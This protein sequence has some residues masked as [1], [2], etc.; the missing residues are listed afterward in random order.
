M[1]AL[2]LSYSNP[3]LAQNN[4]AAADDATEVILI[5]ASLQREA[6]LTSPAS[7]ELA[8]TP[9]QGILIDSAQL[10]GSIS[11]VQADSR[12]NFAQDTRLSVR[13]FGSRSAFGIRSLYLQQDGIPISTPDGQGQLSSILL[14]NIDSVEVLKGPLA[15]LYGNAS[16]GVLSLY[17]RTPTQ[18]SAGLAVAGS[19]QHRQYQVF[20]DWVA[21]DSSLS[22][23][24]KH[25][26]TDGFRPHSRAEKQ[27]AQL[28]YRTTLADTARLSARLDYARDPQLQD[29]LGLSLSD[30]REQPQQTNAAAQLFDTEKNSRQRQFSLSF[31]D[32]QQDDQW[33]LSAWLGERQIN[34]RLAFTGSAPTS[35]GGEVLLDR[36]FSGVNGHY[37]LLHSD[38]YQLRIGASLMQSEDDRLGFVNDFGQ[39][40]ALRRQQTDS[41][42]NRD[43]FVRG[44]WQPAKHW[45]VQGGWRYSELTLKIADRYITADNP[46]DSGTK[47]FYNQAFAA[48]ISYRINTQLSAFVSAAHGFE[49]PT[50]AEI[51]YQA[52]SEG[53]NLALNASRNRQWESG[54]KWQLPDLSGS[55]SA[56]AIQTQDELVVAQAVGGR[57]SYRNAAETARSGVELQLNLRHNAYLRQQLSAHYLSAEFDAGEL[58]GNSLPGVAQRQL[59]W[60][61]DYMPW[62][63]STVLSLYSRYRS[64]VY[65]NDANSNTAPAALS[66]ALAARHS[67]Q[68]QQLTLDYWLA[69]DNLTDKA[70][71]GSVIVNQSNGRAIEPA[72][73]RQLSAGLTARFYWQ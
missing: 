69:V 52:D 13:G 10:F 14:D 28:L 17:S 26:T 30:W 32:Y 49:S 53:V 58:S 46:D 36:Q 8:L 18:N 62:Q 22:A 66:F 19:E 55:A 47:A 72:P 60:Q 2:M 11:G 59:N 4:P 6:W 1:L 41:A 50:L 23:S 3:L 40:G 39:R 42:D 9:S 67:Q 31:S 21:G 44:Q 68:L 27:Q 29:P 54:L 20:A 70:Y 33:Q 61:L 65:I 15:A 56:F 5:S 35:A 63:D 45:Q 57:T 16:G 25:F 48:G 73:G 71:V 37:R 34:Q 7:A 43:L 38:S 64:K 12:A 51:A 24:A